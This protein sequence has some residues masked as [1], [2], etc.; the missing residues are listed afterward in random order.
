MKKRT[1]V[2]VFTL[3]MALIATGIAG[4]D[5]STDTKKDIVTSDNS[6]NENTNSE[7]GNDNAD[8]GNDSSADSNPQQHRL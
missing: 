8:N 3:S 1:K 4:C 2:I 5:S 7:N 6:D